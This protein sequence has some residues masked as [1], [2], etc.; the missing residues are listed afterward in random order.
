[1]KKEDENLKLTLDRLACNNN[2]IIIKDYIINAK[3]LIKQDY[4]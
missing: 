3:P 1:M 4:S 2:E